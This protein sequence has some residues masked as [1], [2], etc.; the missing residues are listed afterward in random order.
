MGNYVI[1]KEGNNYMQIT[2][3]YVQKNLK[4]WGDVLTPPPSISKIL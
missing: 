1:V 2:M 4:K 3:F